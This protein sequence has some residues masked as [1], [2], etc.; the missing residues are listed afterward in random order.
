MDCVRNVS[1][2]SE[3][4][5]SVKERPYQVCLQR[6]YEVLRGGDVESLEEWEKF[7]DIIK[8]YQ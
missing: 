5:K 7:K 3:L 1:T 8:V 2:V 6:K 4:N